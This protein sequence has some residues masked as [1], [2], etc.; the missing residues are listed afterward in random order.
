[1]SLRRAIS[2]LIHD[3]KSAGQKRANH[4]E[5]EDR[6]GMRRT[7]GEG[8]AHAFAVFEVFVVPKQVAI[9]AVMY[10]MQV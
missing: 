9:Y 2:A 8:A 5:L 10:K 1:V 4:R 3:A 6:K 7:V